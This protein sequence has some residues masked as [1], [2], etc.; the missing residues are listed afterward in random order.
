MTILDAPVTP[1]TDNRAS[2]PLWRYATALALA[3]VL[4][5]LSL[6]GGLSAWFLGSV[7]IA[8]LSAAALTFNFHIPGALVRLF[9][10][11]RTAAKY[12]ERLVD[13]KALADQVAR[14]GLFRAMARN[15][16]G[17]AGRLAARRRE[18]KLAD[19]LDDV[20]DVD[21]GKKSCASIYRR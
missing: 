3:A 14:V 19:Y 15:T 10:L 8:G 9:A 4:C 11:G 5:G 1:A 20:E 2:R 12:G 17:S 13:H 6:L 16:L 18:A 7:A 21:F